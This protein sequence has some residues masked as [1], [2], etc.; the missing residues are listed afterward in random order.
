MFLIS[1]LA[2]SVPGQDKGR[3]SSLVYADY[4]YNVTRDSS[5]GSFANAALNGGNAFQA[6]QFRRIYFTYDY[7]LAEEFTSRFRLEADQAALTT[8]GKIGVF[9]KDAFIRWKKIFGTSDLYFGIQPTPAFE[10]S[11][12]VWG[13]RSLEK[14]I[15]DLRGIVGSRDFGVS[16][17]GSMDQE[18]MVQ[19]A[20]LVANGTGN[21]P[22]SDK[23]KR[24]YGH[25][26]LKP[27]AGTDVTLYADYHAR[28]TVTN[29]YGASTPKAKVNNSILTMA[30]FAGIHPAE[31]LRIGAEGFLQ[32]TS[33]G[34]NTGTALATKKA[35]GFSLFARWMAS[36]DLEALVRFDYFDPNTTS[37]VK[38]DSRN[39]VIAG[40]DWKVN[41]NVSV[42]PNLQLETYEKSAAG[43]SYESSLTARITLQ[44]QFP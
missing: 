2:S 24:Y 22:E 8:D 37:S 12:G 32:S 7:D 40:I 6:F 3:F 19:Y 34:F 28:P 21:K 15:L 14:T 10:V 16:L 18:G 44:W 5:S 9:V 42:I 20:V 31:P 17:R 26:R 1:F 25:L 27:L 4:F 30:L 36:T 43:V 38:G 35:M 11:E 13:Y 41:K 23:Y 39:Y 29:P 33:N